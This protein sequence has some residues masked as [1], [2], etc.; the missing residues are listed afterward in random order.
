MLLP[1]CLIYAARCYPCAD[2]SRHLEAG[3][4]WVSLTTPREEGPRVFEGGSGDEGAVGTQQS[5]SDT[6]AGV[7]DVLVGVPSP[8][9]NRSEGEVAASTATF[10]EL[11]DGRSR[12]QLVG[13]LDSVLR[14]RPLPPTCE[15]HL[16]LESQQSLGGGENS[17]MVGEQSVEQQL[18]MDVSTPPAAQAFPVAESRGSRS[19]MSELRAQLSLA[20]NEEVFLAA[21][22][23]DEEDK[24]LVGDGKD[25]RDDADAGEIGI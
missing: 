18:N 1:S 8:G 20:A 19:L 7:T 15:K 6:G 2:N 13:E 12:A 11:V 17:D 22:S 5:I 9:R 16:P 10:Q 24:K 14:A 21:S 23:D 25:N 4:G 3:V